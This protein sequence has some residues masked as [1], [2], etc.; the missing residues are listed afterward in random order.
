M[1]RND[2]RGRTAVV[3]G[4]ASGIGRATA[5]VLIRRG[6]HVVISDIDAQA[7]REAASAIGAEAEPFD[8]VDEIATENAL[9]S[10]EARL[11]PIDALVANAGVIQSG[12]R[13][14]ELSLKEFDRV[15]AVN[16]RGVY[17]VRCRRNPHDQARPRRHR[18]H[19]FGHGVTHGTATRL[20]AVKGSGGPHGLLSCRRVGPL[21]RQSQ[22][23]LTRL[24]RHAGAQ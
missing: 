14:E 4:G 17:I 5:R 19:G 15:I 12:G 1:E 22:R 8:V 9:R 24:R 18:H 21:R 6:W 3:T 10:I 11:G 23:S 7:N 16:L 13:P 20:R 2:G